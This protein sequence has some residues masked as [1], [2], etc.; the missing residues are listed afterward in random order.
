MK[1]APKPQTDGK[2]SQKKAIDHTE[3][4]QAVLNWLASGKFLTSFCKIKGNPGRST[5]YDWM[6]EDPVFA[7]QVARAREDGQEVFFEQSQEIVDEM[8]PGDMNGKIDS[9]Y[10]A[11]QK[12]RIWARME[13][14]KRLNP[15]KYGD[16]LGVEHEG[17]VTLNII[18][19]IPDE[20]Q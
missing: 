13:M 2:K 15:R 7:G 19:G 1:D 4:K 18:T 11:W 6:D 20:Q 12:N 5:V 16:K 8:P 14:L 10:V 17:G 3:Q 9:G